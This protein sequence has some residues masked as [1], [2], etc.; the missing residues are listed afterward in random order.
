M[1]EARSLES[2]RQFAKESLANSYSCVE[3]PILMSPLQESFRYPV[4]HSGLDLTP[5][6]SGCLCPVLSFSETGCS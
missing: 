1:G 2:Q 3:A 5:S 4:P 6:D